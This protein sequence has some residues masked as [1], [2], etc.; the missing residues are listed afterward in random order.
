[1]FYNSSSCAQWIYPLPP[2]FTSSIILFDTS[3]EEVIMPA[4]VYPAIKALLA[5]QNS[6]GRVR[7]YDIL[8]NSQV[9][10]QLS[11]TG[12]KSDFVPFPLSRSQLI[13]AF[14][15][16]GF[17]YLRYTSQAIRHRWNSLNK[18]CN[19]YL[20][21][22]LS[23]FLYIYIITYFFYYVKYLFIYPKT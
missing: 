20:S 15:A 18:V 16:P 9:L 17:Y 13:S 22:L 21:L 10:Y 2:W 1:M 11:Y 3:E 8:I 23:L 7:T 4:L 6:G 12:I 14:R 19:L 5:E